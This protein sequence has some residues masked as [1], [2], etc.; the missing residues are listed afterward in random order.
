M[1]R[2]CFLLPRTGSHTVARARICLFSWHW[3]ASLEPTSIAGVTSLRGH[4]RFA[5]QVRTVGKRVSVNPLS[6]DRSPLVPRVGCRAALAKVRCGKGGQVGCCSCR[7]TTPHRGVGCRA[8][9]VR[10]RSKVR[11]NLLRVRTEGRRPPP[12]FSR[13]ATPRRTEH[14]VHFIVAPAELGPH[15]NTYVSVFWNIGCEGRQRVNETGGD[16]FAAFPEE[17]LTIGIG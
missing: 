14:Q 11:Q 15:A 1:A 10:L 3:T 9:R 7:T 6:A 5:V 12:E 17:A 8:A 16:L 13:R 4:R 2:A